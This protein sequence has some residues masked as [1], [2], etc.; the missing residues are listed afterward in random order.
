MADQD[1]QFR[2]KVALD[3]AEGAK[4]IGEYTRSLRALRGLALEVGDTNTQAFTDIQQAIGA[5]RDRMSD[6]NDSF[7]ALSASPIENVNN[8]IGQVGTS[9]S[10]LDFGGA[11][12]GAKSLNVAL[13][14]F[15]V[16]DLVGEFKQFLVSLGQIV[17]TTKAVETT[18]KANTIART[19]N[20]AA[21]RASTVANE[22]NAV[23]MEAGAV[24]TTEATAATNAFSLALKGTG[25]LLIVGAV[26]ALIA[27]FDK[28]KA[29]GGALSAIFSGIGKA[30]KFVNDGIKN[31]TDALMLTDF[32]GEEASKKSIEG[33]EA[34]Q[35]AIENQIK[36][37]NRLIEF[38]KMAGQNVNAEYTEE[39]KNYAEVNLAL[40]GII[41]KQEELNYLRKTGNTDKEKE[42]TLEKE[43]NDLLQEKLDTEN[44]IGNARLQLTRE[45]EEDNKKLFEET[46]KVEGDRIK[47]EYARNR[48]LAADNRKARK[49]DLDAEWGQ[50]GLLQQDLQIKM[51]ELEKVFNPPFSYDGKPLAVYTKEQTQKAYDEWRDLNYRLQTL[52]SKEANNRKRSRNEE[53]E[54]NKIIA[55]NNLKQTQETAKAELDIIKSI[56]EQSIDDANYSV[57]QRNMI[58]KAGI[59]YQIKYIEDNID[60]L[61]PKDPNLAPGLAQRKQELDARAVTNALIQQ[62]NDITTK[63]IES[64]A[65]VHAERMSLLAEEQKIRAKTLE[66][67]QAAELS[68][69]EAKFNSETKIMDF[70]KMSLEEIKNYNLSEEVRREQFEKDLT[71]L[72]K[73]HEREII[74]ARIAESEMRVGTKT[75]L[76]NANSGILGTGIG[77]GRI[78]AIDAQGALAIEKLNQQQTLQLQNIETGSQKELEIREHYNALIQESNAK[79]AQARRDE[80]AKTAQSVIDSVQSVANLSSAIG[81]LM[82]QRENKRV[83]DGE[84]LAVDAQKKQF[85]RNKAAGIVSAIIN[86]A[87]GITQAWTLP[88]PAN[89]IQAGIIAATGAIQIA[90][91]SEQKFEPD[92]PTSSGGSIGSIGGAPN[93]A[94]TNISTPTLY[95]LGNFNPANIPGNAQQRVYVMESDITNAQQRVRSVQVASEF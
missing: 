83:K 11:I 90:K 49:E 8:S 6:L 31:L 1:L 37:L 20:T 46:S 85:K 93:T 60:K 79:T 91:I 5:A 52:N 66:E 55:E 10:N 36:A 28:L 81:D 69:A 43:I 17:T 40:T 27:N 4:T 9:L 7:N 39:R 88:P 42:K 26:V 89:Y 38:Q 64:A 68:M 34:P 61:F 94:Q 15:S 25:I 58:A 57:E 63:E 30:I 51:K 86:T 95:G 56:T 16:K 24:A 18:T 19:Q 41:R 87:Q 65:K 53:L 23:A 62:R 29:A 72:R 54:Y 75:A 77:A 84:M 33:Y 92:A 80:E 3:G 82:T 35:Q 71:D 22:T 21:V 48:K 14:S 32:A 12:N 73:K 74:D 47:N 50:I 13:K 76:A 45:L 70:T 78:E 44:K 2:I 59:D 67:Q